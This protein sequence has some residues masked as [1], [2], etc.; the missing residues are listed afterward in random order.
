MDDMQIEYVKPTKNISIG[1]YGWRKRCLYG[2]LILLSLIV[3]INL[4][5][6]FWLSIVL[7]LQWVC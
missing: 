7:G 4:C 2:L 5:L 1:I 3:C 6:T